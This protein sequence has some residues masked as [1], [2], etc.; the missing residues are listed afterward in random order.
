MAK[1]IE[2][3]QF[4]MGGVGRALFGLVV[5]H[6]PVLRERLGIDIRY[7]ALVDSSHALHIDFNSSVNQQYLQFLWAR[8]KPEVGEKIG[9][10][11]GAVSRPSAVSVLATELDRIRRE[12]SAV[13]LVAVDV[14]GAADTEMTPVITAALRQGQYAVLANKR[15]LCCPMDDF[16]QMAAAAGAGMARLRYET[17]VGAAL[18]IVSTIRMLFDSFDEI[19][20]IAGC[21]SG[22][23]GFLT[24]E[25]EAGRKYS[26][27]VAEAKAKGY[28]E[29]DPRDDLGGVDVAR[30]ALILA[31][32]LGYSAELRDVEVEALYPANLAELSVPDFMAR[33]PELNEHY[34]NL[35]REAAEQG[36]TL[37][38]V[39][40]VNRQTLK[41]GLEKVA[42][43]S[44]I[45]R[46][47]G[48]D[49][50]A[51]FRTR[52]YNPQPM[53]IQGRGAG[54][55]VTASGVLADIVSL[56]R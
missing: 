10:Q 54:P 40:T 39:A 46:L 25:I 11:T 15:P 35:S 6:G 51:V 44:Q 24:T 49:N 28:T 1:I 26:E 36:Q 31:R 32:S 56:G 29:P 17:T 23:L 55:E 2:L 14:S 47:R 21:F 5:Q 52:R 16:K 53:V 18:P 38:Y 48:P 8:L 34:T 19:N 41:V 12:D 37:R 9:D 22:T 4:G 13:K 50:I 45:G 43:D 42:H 33:L 27:V 7:R 3:V 20:E 30:K